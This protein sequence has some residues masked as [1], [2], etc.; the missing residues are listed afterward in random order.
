MEQENFSGFWDW[1]KKRREEQSE[2]VKPAE[3][4]LEIKVPY[5]I[6]TQYKQ[7]ENATQIERGSV[8]VDYNIYGEETDE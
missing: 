1:L 2:G 3:L 6:P 5:I 7:S 8:I 4:T